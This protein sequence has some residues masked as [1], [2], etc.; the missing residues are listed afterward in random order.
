MSENTVIIIQLIL[1]AITPILGGL[2]VFLRMKTERR[3]EEAVASEHEA[4]AASTLTG[5]ALD[6]VKTLERQQAEQAKELKALKREVRYWK[7]GCSKLIKQVTD[8]G[9]IPVWEPNGFDAS[10]EDPQEG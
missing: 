2:A 10:L 1:T 5:S 7:R 3:K 6:I 9:M 4:T 8:A